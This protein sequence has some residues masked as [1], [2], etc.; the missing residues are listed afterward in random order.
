MQILFLSDML[1]FTKKKSTNVH[2]GFFFNF[3]LFVLNGHIFN[4]SFFPITSQPLHYKIILNSAT[5][6]TFTNDEKIIYLHFM[7]SFYNNCS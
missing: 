7:L 3:I 1:K 6:N 2:A 4:S 5:K